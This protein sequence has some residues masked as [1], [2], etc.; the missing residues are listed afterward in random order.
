MHHDAKISTQKTNDIRIAIQHAQ[1]MLQHKA[2][3]PAKQQGCEI[4]KIFPDEPNALFIVGVSLKGL[5]R[6]DEAKITLQRLVKQTKGFALA[7]QELGFTLHALGHVKKAM[8][9][10]RD[11]I[12]IESNL[13]HSW[14]LLLNYS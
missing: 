9:S 2:Y 6:F 8:T 13:P 14:K 5:K 12:Q 7:H 3:A 10:L 1:A 11:A 4:L